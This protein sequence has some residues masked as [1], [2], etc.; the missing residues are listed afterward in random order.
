MGIRLSGAGRGVFLALFGAVVV[1]ALVLWA[2]SRSVQAD[3][4]KNDT[5]HI[6]RIEKHPTG[7]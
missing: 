2:I 3:L 6:E 5:G 7:K 4:K 1:V